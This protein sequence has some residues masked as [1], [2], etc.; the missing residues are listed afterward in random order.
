MTHHGSPPAAC[1]A[2]LAADSAVVAPPRR[3]RQH[4]GAPHDTAAMSAVRC[5]SAFVR[6]GFLRRRVPRTVPPTK[7][8]PRMTIAP[9]TR[10]ADPALLPRRAAGASAPSPRSW[11]SITARCSACPGAGRPARIG[12]RRGASKID[13]Y[14]PFIRETLA[15][16]P[17]LTASRLYVMASERGYRGRPGSLSPSDRAAPAAPEG[18]SV[19]AA[20]HAA[21]A[22]RRR[23]TGVTSATSRSAAPADR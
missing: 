9:E 7:R 2:L 3:P 19:P 10:S 20:A 23:S 14:L 16:F 1:D 12:P 22:S 8:N 15:Q 17:T 21:R 18:R 4:P 6:L 5:C 13:P 11:A